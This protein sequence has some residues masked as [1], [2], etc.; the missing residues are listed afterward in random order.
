LI[1]YYD[2]RTVIII[3]GDRLTRRFVVLTN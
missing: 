3:E 1:Y 2:K